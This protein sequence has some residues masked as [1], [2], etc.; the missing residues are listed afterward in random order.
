MT[1]SPQNLVRDHSENT[2]QYWQEPKSTVKTRDSTGKNLS[3]TDDENQIEKRFISS[4]SFHRTAGGHV[5]E[6]TMGERL[7]QRIL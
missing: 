6:T 3:E 4:Q 2:R 7:K 1:I 5:R